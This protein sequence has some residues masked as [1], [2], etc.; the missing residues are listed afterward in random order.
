MTNID[1]AQNETIMIC[2]QET[3]KQILK[4]LTK[5]KKLLNIKLLTKK[6]LI[7]KLYFS[8]DYNAILYLIEKYNYKYASNCKYGSYFLISN[9]LLLIQHFILMLNR[10]KTDQTYSCSYRKKIK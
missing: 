1:D 5:E 7:N 10:T 4:Q 9:M 8:Y 2:E 6:E 3:K